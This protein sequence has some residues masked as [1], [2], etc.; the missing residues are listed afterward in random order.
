MI[1]RIKEYF[2]NRRIKKV[3]KKSSAD[4]FTKEIEFEYLEN[5]YCKNKSGIDRLLIYCI[6]EIASDRTPY[7]KRGG[8]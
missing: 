2:E 4:I 5:K 3:L 7:T 1:E 6:L 8:I